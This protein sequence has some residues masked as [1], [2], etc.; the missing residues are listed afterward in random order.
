MR[1]SDCRAQVAT[2][3]PDRAVAQVSTCESNMRSGYPGPEWL[4]R[5][6]GFL[7]KEAPIGTGAKCFESDPLVW[8]SRH[9]TDWEW[10]WC[11]HRV[12]N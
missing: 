10:L 12:F 9:M 1:P 2:P 5:V 3:D 4:W 7:T 8:R 11:I 6:Y